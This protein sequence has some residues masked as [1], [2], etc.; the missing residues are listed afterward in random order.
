MLFRIGLVRSMLE[1]PSTEGSSGYSE[2]GMP[3]MENSEGPQVIWVIIFSS[4]RMVTVSSGS[5]L[6]ISP[7]SLALRTTSPGSSTWASITVVM[8]SSRS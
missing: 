4:T 1:A 6:T 7:N 5:L 3:T 8:P 2:L